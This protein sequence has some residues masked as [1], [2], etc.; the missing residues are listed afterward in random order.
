[1]GNRLIF[2][3]SGV[4]AKGG[5]RRLCWPGDGCPGLS[6]EAGFPGKSGKSRLRRDDDG[7]TVLKQQ[8]LLLP[9]KA[10]KHQAT[11]KSYPQT[12]TGGQVENTKALERTRVKGIRQNGAVTSGEG[13]LICR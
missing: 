12:D 4:T 7:T 13:T 1:M 9:G 10:S 5:R 3:Y 6:V 8:M 2:L 11:S